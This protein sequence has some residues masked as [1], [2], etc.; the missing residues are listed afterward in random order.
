MDYLNYSSNNDDDDDVD[1]VSVV[2]DD[3]NDEYSCELI[4]LNDDLIHTNE[5]V[6]SDL[7]FIAKNAIEETFSS[8][9]TSNIQTSL[10]TFDHNVDRDYNNNDDDDE[11]SDS[12]IDSK[13]KNDCNININNESDIDSSS[14]SSDSECAKSNKNKSNHNY[15]KNILKIE[16]FMTEEEEESSAIGPMK[17]KNEIEEV[18]ED[19]NIKKIDLELLDKLVTIGHV[20]Y[21]IDLEFVIVIQA[22]FTNNP[23]SEG[24]FKY[25]FVYTIFFRLLLK[26]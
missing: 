21:R 7:E 23:L 15:K 26:S 22:A 6:M 8:Y 4:E 2:N 13:T 18:V 19:V 1:D 3:D 20:L 17:T 14:S 16:S 24:I 12:D 9:T 25:I 11:S 10:H 5:R